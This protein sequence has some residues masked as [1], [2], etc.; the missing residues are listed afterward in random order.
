MKKRPLW[1]FLC[2][3]LMTVQYSFAQELTAEICDKKAEAILQFKNDFKDYPPALI[4]EL[5]E[6]ITPC[7]EENYSQT[8]PASTYAK[9]LLH[10]QKGDFGYL[11]G[12]NW[13][14]S[15]F[16]LFRSSA[17]NNYAPGM[18]TY[19]TYML[20]NN[21]IRPRDFINYK[22]IRQDFE[23]LLSQGYKPDEVNYVLGYLNLKGLLGINSQVSLEERIIRAK[24]HFEDSNHPMAKH[25]LAIMHYYGYGMPQ[26][27]AK[28]LQIL[29]D[30]DILNSRTLLSYLQ[31]QNTDWIPISAEEF[32]LQF[33]YNFP[34][35]E[36]HTLKDKVYEGHLIE[37]HIVPKEEGVRRYMPM[38]LDLSYRSTSQGD[39]NTGYKL[40]LDGQTIWITGSLSNSYN[41]VALNVPYHHSFSLPPLENLLQDHPDKNT[42][43][44]KVSGYIHIRETTINGKTALVGTLPCVV[45]ERNEPT[46]RI[47]RFVLY[48]KDGEPELSAT[49]GT[50]TTKGSNILDKNF[51]T[52]SPNPIGNQ[53][54][55]TYTL[56]QPS[57][58][59]VAVYD[60]FGQQRI[61]VPVQKN[62]TNGTQ[63]ITVDSAGLPGGTYII[64]MMIDGQPYSKTV[65]KE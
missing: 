6:Y 56:D 42:V 52:I 47:M 15:Q 8:S 28:G 37:Y 39:S 11:F 49:S 50:L 27:K 38:S 25:W 57:T 51:A 23:W 64:Q 45:A 46:G 35:P 63:T 17:Y 40:T 5:I 33:S 26:D 54:T 34:K 19:G 20:S 58:I 61:Q 24:K 29:A 1:G 43:T 41:S 2:L 60:F 31:N 3:I 7:A 16:Y 53:F 65:I 14:L 30:N 62:T 21:F 48:P 32:P 18:F 22:E 44:Y 36:V 13:E 55:I 59:E 12:K 10:H 9:G 4:N